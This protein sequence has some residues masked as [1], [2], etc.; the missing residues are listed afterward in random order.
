MAEGGRGAAGTEGLPGQT[1]AGG[2]PVLQA[3][4]FPGLF[5]IA[6]KKAIIIYWLGVLPNPSAQKEERAYEISGYAL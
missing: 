4:S 6:G 2:I 1:A 5:T 3:E